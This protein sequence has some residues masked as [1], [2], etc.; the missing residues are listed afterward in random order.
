MELEL[1]QCF[2]GLHLLMVLNLK[3]R[4]LVCNTF[5]L[6]LTMIELLVYD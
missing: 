4:C 5:D 1:F 2:L 6:E 3:I